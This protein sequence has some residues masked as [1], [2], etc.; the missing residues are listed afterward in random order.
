[1]RYIT[2]FNDQATNQKPNKPKTK[3]KVQQLTYVH[4]YNI[5]YQIKR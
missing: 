1:M 4:E 3:K 2:K 5:I